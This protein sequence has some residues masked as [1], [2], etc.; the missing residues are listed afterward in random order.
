MQTLLSTSL[1]SKSVETV[2]R[3][4][5]IQKFCS[6]VYPNIILKLGFMELGK[7]S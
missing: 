3:A 6:K 4:E 5:T 1:E 7:S 2:N